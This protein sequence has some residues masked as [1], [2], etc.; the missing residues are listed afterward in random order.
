MCYSDCDKA[1]YCVYNEGF[2]KEGDWA[3]AYKGAIYE[4]IIADCFSKMARPLYYYHK[5]SGLEINFITSVNSE[6]T[7]VEVKA[8]TGNTKSSNTILKNKSQYG[9][10][11]CIKLSS[12]NVGFENEKLTIP[13]YMAHLLELN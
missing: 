9:V 5:E 2:R 11:F 13:Y 3:I 8:T 6:P 12:N 4:N 1:G 10:N 7:L